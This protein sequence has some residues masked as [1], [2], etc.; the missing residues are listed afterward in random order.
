MKNLFFIHTPLQL[1]VAQQI[2]RQEK[3]TNNVLLYSYVK[4]NE[5]FLKIYDLIIIDNFWEKTIFIKDL[6]AIGNIHL[7]NPIK[8]FIEIKKI[9]KIIKDEKINNLYLSDIKNISTCFY[10]LLFSS[11]NIKI[12]IFEE[13]S[14]HYSES[15]VYKNTLKK[16]IAT[17]ILDYFYY[18]PFYSFKFGKY[19]FSTQELSNDKT[20]PIDIR[21]NILP[22]FN[23]RFD[24]SLSIEP[25]FSK[26]TNDY[27]DKELNQCNQNEQSQILL[28]QPFEDRDI[29]IKSIEIYL[30]EYFNYK[31]IYIKFHP[32]DTVEFKERVIEVVKRNNVDYTILGID[33]NIPI[34]YY[35]QKER[36]DTIVNFFSSV[37]MYNGYIYKKKNVISLMSLYQRLYTEKYGNISQRADRCIKLAKAFDTQ[38][39]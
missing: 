4:E 23:E 15:I 39:I 20:L 7:H 38:F 11:I 3:L 18:L 34:E 24:R 32:R 33:Y 22:Y 37:I 26:K 25:L 8:T 19:I 12:N 35:L 14:S 29:F 36:F 27:L 13:G 1:F 9:K 6:P 31:H 10:S 30:S 17:L 5:H 16:K 2:I 28:T 21:Y